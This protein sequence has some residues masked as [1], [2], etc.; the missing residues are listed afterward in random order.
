MRK[1]L[2]EVEAKRGGVPASA[3]LAQVLQVYETPWPCMIM[4]YESESSDLLAVLRRDD[5]RPLR[6]C[7]RVLYELAAAL[8]A[9]HYHGVAHG[10]VAPRN[11]MV[12]ADGTVCVIDMG[13]SKFV[14]GMPKADAAAAKADDVLGLGRIIRRMLQLCR[15]AAP[16]RA[17][18]ERC[19][20]DQALE[21]CGVCV[22]VCVRPVL[23]V[24]GIAGRAA[25]VLTR[26]WVT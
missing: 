16:L 5:G 4:K 9:L 23:V 22:F 13:L 10:D 11:V 3:S 21:R 17:L 14:E 25:H 6:W 8:A 1:K 15:A 2:S 24:P 26:M 18:W 7:L 20:A 12:R 19:V